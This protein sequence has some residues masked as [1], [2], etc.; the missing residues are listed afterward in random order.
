MKSDDMV[1]AGVDKSVVGTQVKQMS[2]LAYLI[3]IRT[4][5]FYNQKEIHFLSGV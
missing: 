5:R 4:S 2:C 3:L 1:K